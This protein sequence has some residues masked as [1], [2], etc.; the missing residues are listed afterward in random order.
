MLL[1][2]VLL[3]LPDFTRVSILGFIEFERKVKHQ[4]EQIRELQSQVMNLNIRQSATASVIQTD[5]DVLV[6]V[7][8]VVVAQRDLQE[9]ADIFGGG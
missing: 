2:F 4:E 5:K 1:A 8:E 3:L 6:Q 9:K 7:N